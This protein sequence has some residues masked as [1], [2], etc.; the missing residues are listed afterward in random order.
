MLFV[1][2]SIFV[3]W[4]N[5]FFYIETNKWQ[6]FQFHS[7]ASFLISFLYLIHSCTFSFIPTPHKYMW[8]DSRYAID[9][10]CLPKGFRS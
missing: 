3:H 10:E 5:D 9:Y 4:E 6:P 7:Y 8:R 2:D 1:H